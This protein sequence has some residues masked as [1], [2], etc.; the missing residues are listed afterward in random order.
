MRRRL[1]RSIR[2]FHER[3]MLTFYP[4]L[5]VGLATTPSVVRS[6][7]TRTSLGAASGNVASSDG[8]GSALRPRWFEAGETS[9]GR[10]ERAE[11]ARQIPGEANPVH[12]VRAE[13]THRTW[14]LGW[15]SRQVRSTW[16]AWGACC[17]ATGATELD[18]LGVRG[19]T[20]TVKSST[21]KGPEGLAGETVWRRCRTAKD[22]SLAGSR[23]LLVSTR[24]NR[25]ERGPDEGRARGGNCGARE[26][27]RRAKSPEGSHPLATRPHGRRPPITR[28][29]LGQPVW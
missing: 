28:E 15:K 2:S 8:V 26:G 29:S 22:S 24:R 27:A 18:Q 6:R 17:P 20:A 5:M 11:R 13:A 14:Q 12:G 1:V 16:P 4:I 10:V 9:R 19:K 23:E 7:A 21:M 25:P 3:G